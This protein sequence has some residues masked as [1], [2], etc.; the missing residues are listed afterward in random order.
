[1]G[2]ELL[3]RGQSSLNELAARANDAHQRVGDAII[4]TLEAVIAAGDA[5]LLAREQVGR[6][7]W[8]EWVDENLDFGAH[9]ARGYMRVA[10]HREHLAPILNGERQL[11]P[12][13]NGRRGAVASALLYLRGLPT[14]EGAR[15]TPYPQDMKDEAR[16]LVENGATQFEAAEILGV[17]RA[18]LRKWPGVGTGRV[19]MP[20][21][22]TRAK[23]AERRRRANR[24]RAARK[25]LREKE[26]DRRARKIEGPGAEAYSLLR[27][28][29]QQLTAAGGGYGTA[30]AAVERAVEETWAALMRE[31]S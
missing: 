1:M 11:P 22:T 23:L 18:V 21:G 14:I 4:Q 26:R 12:A 27:R 31:E 13:K 10:Y 24:D 20:A 3:E 9:T 7:G 5:L 29:G 28:A 25:A 2:Q 17:S 16:R 19:G 8:E 6:G 15:S 30:Y